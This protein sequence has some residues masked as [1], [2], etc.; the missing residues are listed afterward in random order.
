MSKTEKIEKQFT[1]KEALKLLGMDYNFTNRQRLTYLRLGRNQKQLKKD[2][3]SEF[4]Y[5]WIPQL[6]ENTDWIY[7]RG[8]VLYTEAGIEK[9]QDI[10]HNKK[11]IY[12]RG[13]SI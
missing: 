8:K 1:Q 5:C 11:K 4:T 3:K 6:N 10:F 7:M 2:G 12:I 13:N 9:L